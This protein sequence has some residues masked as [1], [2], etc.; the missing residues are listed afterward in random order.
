MMVTEAMGGTVETGT[1]VEGEEREAVGVGTEGAEVGIEG[2][3]VGIE[4]AEGAGEGI[5]EE[6][7]MEDLTIWKSTHSTC[8]D[9]H[10][11]MY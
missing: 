7:L 5:E 1:V 10:Q 11:S 8:R 2:A 9:W 6:K 3:E 4:G